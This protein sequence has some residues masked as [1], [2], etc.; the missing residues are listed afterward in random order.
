MIIKPKRAET[1][2]DPGSFS[3]S[4]PLYAAS[5]PFPTNPEFEALKERVLRTRDTGEWLSWFVD[6][7]PAQEEIFEAHGHPKDVRASVVEPLRKLYPPKVCRALLK[8][9]HNWQLVSGLFSP[10][11]LD[12]VDLI[13]LGTRLIWARPWFDDDLLG[14]LRS[15]EH[16]AAA[17]TEI[18]V[19]ANLEQHGMRYDREPRGPDGT[20]PDFAV[21]FNHWRYIVEVKTLRPSDGERVAEGVSRGM[22]SAADKWRRPG[23]HVQVQA[24]SEVRAL[25]E[26]VEGRKTLAERASE[27]LDRLAEQGRRW[28][29]APAA[30][31]EHNVGEWFRVRVS[32]GADHP[33]GTIATAVWEG[34]ED[35]RRAVRIAS[36]IEGAA[37]QIPPAAM[38]VPLVYVAEPIPVAIVR[39]VLL[40]RVAELPVLF[41]PIQ[42]VILR[43][44]QRVSPVRIEPVVVTVPLR[45]AVSPA[46]ARLAIVLGS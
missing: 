5:E 12:A 43:W 4:V 39:A 21:Y 16:V 9:P 34:P 15:S 6:V 32:E 41:S 22:S 2:F 44:H 40:R 3:Y 13:R 18:D 37:L 27:E 7:S 17:S 36:I 38:G 23:F 20:L 45:R 28:S 19:W 24:T 8:H 29:A 11:I 33:A 31:G 46:E 14:K 42:F 30:V 26:D 35:E 25:L 10:S 1:D